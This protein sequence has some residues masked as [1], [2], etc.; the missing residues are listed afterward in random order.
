MIYHAD[1]PPKSISRVPINGAKPLQDIVKDL[2]KPE[3]ITLDW[4]SEKVYW[5]DAGKNQIGVANQDGSWKKILYQGY[6]HEKILTV[7]V[8]LEKKY[9]YITKVYVK[10]RCTSLQELP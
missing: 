4:I 3:G 9:L 8:Y 5:A 7:Q 2:E 1:Q 6:N 10:S